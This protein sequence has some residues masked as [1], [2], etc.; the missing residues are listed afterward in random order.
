MQRRWVFRFM[1]NRRSREMGL[2]GYPDVSLA[3][4]R[5]QTTKCRKQVKAR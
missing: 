3:E 4:A 5:N 1:L 2:G